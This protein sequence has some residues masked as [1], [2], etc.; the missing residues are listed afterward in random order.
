MFY[1]SMFYKSMFYKSVFYKSMFYKSV[2][3]KSSPCF[4]NPIHSKFYNMPLV[5]T[6]NTD[7]GHVQGEKSANHG[8]PARIRKLR[9]LKHSGLNGS[10]PFS[11]KT[12]VPVLLRMLEFKGKQKRAN[13]RNLVPRAHV[14]FGQRQDTK[15]WNNQFPE[16]QDFRSSGFTEK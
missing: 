7:S 16:L 6:K 13:R 14:S 1:K 12:W 3:Y 4:T 15:L 5:S 10:T 8:L 11:Q 9:N 2:F